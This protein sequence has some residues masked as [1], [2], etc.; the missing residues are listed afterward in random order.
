MMGLLTSS[1]VAEGS[2]GPSRNEFAAKAQ[3][4]A[5][6]WAERLGRYTET[7]LGMEDI[8]FTELNERRAAS[9]MEHFN[10]LRRRANRGALTL[11]DMEEIERAYKR[12][13]RE[14]RTA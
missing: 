8:T 9:R 11:D 7:E 10:Y 12:L 13:P 4:V 6:W 1:L 5:E 2:S 14:W 3:R